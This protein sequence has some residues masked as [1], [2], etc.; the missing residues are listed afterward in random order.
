MWKNIQLAPADAIFGLNEAFKLDSNPNKVNL[1]V[2]VYQNEKGVT[3]I[4]SCVKA[5]EQILLQKETSKTYLPIS[6]D[7]E[8][9]MEVQKLIFGGESEV[10]L[11]GRAATVQT[12]GGTGGL[13]VGADLLHTFLPNATVWISAPS[14]ANHTG[15]FAAAGF[16]LD[17][18][19]YYD[20]E[21]K[22][23]DFAGMKDALE[24]IPAGDIV[25]LHACCHNPSG[26][27]LNADQWQEVADIA[28][29]CGWLA[30]LDFAYQGF[31]DGLDED[32]LGVAAF[33]ATGGD[34]CVASSFSKNF[35]LYT[36]RVGA[37]T[38][39]TPAAEEAA[40]ALSHLKIAIRVNFSNPPAHGAL[41]VKTVLTDATLRGEW[42]E[43]LAAMRG[44]I[45]EMRHALVDGLAGRGVE[46]DFSYITAQKGMFSFSGL[47]QEMV[48]WL[49]EEMGVYMV[50]AGRINAAGLNSGNIDY[51]C[52]AIAKGLK[53]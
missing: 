21:N 12:P 40:K 15:I 19:P 25:L 32:R 30:F 28:K 44:R 42:R 7:P 36:E 24:K 47:S 26:F 14:W 45:K 5:A 52:D 51:V 50:G 38:M 8:Y 35:G 9:D 53:R 34:F 17:S 4:M 3:P 29:R 22:G 11:S 6:G 20:A 49:R 18:Y 41:V 27:D 37:M 23:V 10:V 16:S 13:R 1:A 48:A 2:G 33:A 39:V 31:G 43:E 46:Q